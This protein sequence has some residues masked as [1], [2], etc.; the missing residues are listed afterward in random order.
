MQDYYTAILDLDGSGSTSFFGVFDGHGGHRVALYC[1]RKFHTELVKAPDY[2]N[3]LHTALGL[4]CFRID[5]ALKRS[6][7]WKNPDAPPAPGNRSF[8]S[9]L[10]TSLCS[11]FGKKYEVPQIEGS[12]ACV[13]LIRGNQIIVGNVGDSRCVLSRNGQAIDLSTDHKPNEPGERARIEAAGGSVV[14]RQVLVH[15]ASGRMRIELVPYRVDGI[16]A[17]S[18]A[19]GD[20]Q[21]KKNNRLKL[22]C[23]PDIH[24]EDITDDIDF[25]LIASDGIWEVKTS[26][27][28]VTYVNERLQTNYEGPQIE[29]STACM[30]LIGG[31]QIIVGNIGD[32]RCVLSRNGQAIDLSTDHKPNEPGERA[33]IEAAGGSV[34]QREVLV[35]DASGR[36]RIELGPYRVN[37]IIA[38]SRALGDFQFKKNNRLKLICNPDIHTEDITDDI[39]FLLIAS[40][41]IWEVKTSEEVVTYVNERLQ[42]RADPCVICEG[43]L[44]WCRESRDNSTVILAQFKNHNSLTANV[45]CSGLSCPRP[46]AKTTDPSSCIA[47]QIFVK[48]LSSKT[49]TLSVKNL[50]SIRTIKSKIQDK[51]GIPLEVQGLI[52]AG[53]QL[54]DGLTLA[55][56]SIEKESTVHLVVGL[57]GG[58][59]SASIQN[60]TVEGGVAVQSFLTQ[61]CDLELLQRWVG[62]RIINGITH[63]SAHELNIYSTAPSVLATQYS[64]VR[65]DD[66]SEA[67]YF[68]TRLQRKGQSGSRVNRSVD[69]DGV[70][71]S[72]HGEHKARPVHSAPRDGHTVGFRRLFSFSRKDNEDNLIRDGWIMS[73]YGL[74]ENEANEVVLCKIHRTTYRSDHSKRRKRPRLDHAS[75]VFSKRRPL[76]QASTSHTVHEVFNVYELSPME[77]IKK[78]PATVNAEGTPTW[79]FYTSSHVEGAGISETG[80]WSSQLEPI[81][82]VHDSYGQILGHVQF[83]KFFESMDKSSEDL[84][85]SGYTMSQ[86]SGKNSQLDDIVL[87]TMG[88]P[89]AVEFKNG[90]NPTATAN[91][92]CSGDSCPRPQAKTTDPSSSIG[93]PKV[94]TKAEI[95]AAEE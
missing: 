60:S 76:Q 73:E 36:M 71:W 88:L 68:F 90:N 56:Y 34:V 14:Q 80:R 12:T 58:Q 67:W 74:N 63:P 59:N 64:S 4:A 41:G 77:L 6:D 27:E 49:I 17:I 50:D 95:K 66:G 55:H 1:S 91:A 93:A 30:A 28:V 51:E 15:D 72:W 22:I 13:A 43:L 31:N 20:F 40:D 47:I 83:V 87:C 62:P 37:G 48:T 33:R 70:T 53:K 79:Y 65:A 84:L 23:N 85:F 82:F 24:T 21:F 92:S 18:R 3:N 75:G 5:Q 45:S 25:L 86:F 81:Q 54:E 7:E 16:I 94:D 52:F 39:D 32:S 57:L 78:Y 8:R 42:T 44:E 19:L 26:E 61:P 10:Q 89:N 29:G 69:V 2:Q 38:V 11:C 46:Q 9:R 35:Y